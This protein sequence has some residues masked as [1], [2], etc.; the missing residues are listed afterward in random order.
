MADLKIKTW[1]GLNNRVAHERTAA[2][3]MLSGI[4][5]T[6]NDGGNL[7][8]RTGI[9]ARMT[10][11]TRM[12]SL[13]SGGGVAL[14]VN[15]RAL[16]LVPSGGMSAMP[17]V[18]LVSDAPMAYCQIEG[19]IYYSNGTDTGVLENGARR[20]WGIAP[21][22][23]PD[24]RATP[25]A[26]DAG[27]YKWAMTYL[28]SDGQ[29][30]G[31][32]DAGLIDVGNGA[33]LYWPSLPTSTDPTVAYKVLYLSAADGEVMYRAL[34]LDASTTTANFT[35]GTRE[36]AWPL[37]TQHLLPAPAGQCLTFFQ[38]RM[39]VAAG[40]DLYP[41]QP[42]SNELFDL[43]EFVPARGRVTML[44]PR[45]DDKAMLVGTDQGVGWLIGD[46]LATLSYEHALDD[47]VLPGSLAWVPGE[48]LGKGEAGQT[49][50]PMWA[51]AEGIY[52]AAPPFWTVKPITLDR[53]QQELQGQVAAVFDK[54]RGQYLAIISN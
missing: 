24:A 49:M 21:P 27:T 38:G 11:A 28:R 1:A 25:G 17:L 32:I 53:V 5:V 30:S 47:P 10:G 42:F 52:T 15:N 12:H 37:E 6:L 19:V 22:H 36:L 39:W 23:C 43:R 7:S 31:A 2:G 29:E 35:G 46:S 34:I 50:L 8:R 33:G 16:C 51:G 44:A 40:A 20:S 3:D 41:S 26:L 54:A 14:A 18:A 13:W 4:N 9:T 45:P 48:A